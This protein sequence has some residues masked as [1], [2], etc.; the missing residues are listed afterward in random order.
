MKCYKIEEVNNTESSS[1]RLGA[2]SRGDLDDCEGGVEWFGRQDS[3]Y[4]GIHIMHW[5]TC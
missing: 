5:D 4:D 3:R 2:R 1:G